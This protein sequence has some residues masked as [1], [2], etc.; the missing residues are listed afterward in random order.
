AERAWATAQ[1]VDAAGD[2]MSGNLDM[3]NNNITNINDV[4]D[5]SNLLAIDV[6]GR[7]IYYT[8]GGSKVVNA[9]S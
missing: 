9:S 8:D 6:D 5:N 4:K 2:S 3:G 7:V 1:F